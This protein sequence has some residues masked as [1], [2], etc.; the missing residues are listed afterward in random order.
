MPHLKKKSVLTQ[1]LISVF[2]F[3]PDCLE[4][5]Q[6]IFLEN[7]QQPEKA[8][9]DGKQQRFSF[10]KRLL[11]ELSKNFFIKR[12]FFYILS[13][14]KICLA[15]H[16]LQKISEL[17]MWFTFSNTKPPPQPLSNTG[18]LTGPQV[19]GKANPLQNAFHSWVHQLENCFELTME[20]KHPHLCENC[21]ETKQSY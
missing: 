10:F 1:C 15:L 12:D 20:H 9:T 14:L 21:S 2:L 8:Y 11:R 13:L 16:Y 3:L 18:Q 17:F 7:G 19:S 5:R 6:C 4:C